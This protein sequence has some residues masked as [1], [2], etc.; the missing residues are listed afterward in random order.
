[1][2]IGN[3]RTRGCGN[4]GDGR[5]CC[6]LWLLPL[7]IPASTAFGQT[8]IR[9][10]EDAAGVGGNAESRRPA[11]SADGRYIAFA[12][13][14][15]NLVTGDSNATDDIFL[16]DRVTGSIDM[17][18]RGVGGVPAN[19]KS[20]RPT[21]SADGQFVAF[22][23]DATNLI[24]D[25]TN[26][27]RD[28]FVYDRSAGTIEL[29]SVGADGRRGEKSSNMPSISADGRFVAFR[30]LASTL[31]GEA[32]TLG[33]RDIFVRDRIN[34]VTERISVSSAGE[35]ATGGHSDRPV[36]SADGRYVAF[37]SDAGNLVEGDEPSFD[38]LNPTL[39]N[40]VRDVFLHDRNTGV[41]ERISVATDGTPGN[42]A[43]SRAA[44][45]ADGRYVAF[46]SEAT[47]LVA[48]DTN[49]VGDVFL[50][51]TLEGTTVR[52]S[53]ASGGVEADGLSSVPA[54]SADARYIAFR[55]EATNLAPVS[56]GA[57]AGVEQVY[58]Y[59]RT[60]MTVTL[61]SANLAGEAGDENS[62]RPG[63]SADASVVAFRSRAANLIDGD[64]PTFHSVDCPA[65]PGSPDVFVR[66]LDSD[67]DGVRETG[68]NCPLISNASQRDIDNDGLG[69]ACDDDRDGD[70]T[71]N[72]TDQ[73]P[74]DPAKTA[75][76]ECGCG[77]PD[78]DDGSG[79]IV[80]VDDCPNDPAKT[81]AGVC[82]CGFPDI[83]DGTGNIVC[84]DACPDDPNKTLPG[85]CGCGAVDDDTDGDGTPDCEDGC[86]DADYK[87]D[88][89][90]CGCDA[91]DTD[92][93]QDGV[94]NCL[95]NC[96]AIPNPDQADADGD[97]L[98]D[99]CDNDS[100]PADDGVVNPPDD[101]GNGNEP[102]QTVPGTEEPA[103]TTTTGLSSPCGA[104]G[105]VPMLFTFLGLT[106]L[107]RRR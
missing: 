22:Y 5:F 67:S 63:V 57:V 14:A 66:S 44:I 74:D 42:G 17:I 13:D 43:S 6:C 95:D 77:T 70:G 11:V 27:K 31:D 101:A 83:D 76:G 78:T 86:P 47:N 34:N 94:P 99:A 93:D 84:E 12:S 32:D 37:Y 68:D 90:A 64:E 65:C 53:L 24:S 81:A 96:D 23:S 46:R 92:V 59:D 15:S 39:G 98:G 20:D 54:M 106:A 85:V 107:K 91:L 16:F 36:I 79:G 102:G 89:G 103:D 1:M 41:T 10:S 50:R 8:L 21:I 7:L 45:S 9:A 19:G 40:G 26:L 62:S 80:C 69:D 49:G 82:G 33:F 51:D 104:F 87:T 55:S 38:P 52:V 18:T 29:V 3:K 35:L 71:P 105:L 73:C 97:G 30:S 4:I 88:P 25:D 75:S 56:A 61:V 60:T 48:G 100:P 28:I 58:I 2:E 72:A